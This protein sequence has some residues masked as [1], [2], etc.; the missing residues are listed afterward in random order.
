MRLGHPCWSLCFAIQT[1]LA[2][3]SKEREGKKKIIFPMLPSLKRPK[4]TT[5]CDLAEPP[6]FLLDPAEATNK[7][8]LEAFEFFFEKLSKLKFTETTPPQI[9]SEEASSSSS[10]YSSRQ[11]ISS[12]LPSSD[13]LALDVTASRKRVSRDMA[14]DQ[15]GI[16]G[17][18]DF[19]EHIERL[20][21]KAK[22]DLQSDQFDPEAEESKVVVKKELFS[23]LQSQYPSLKIDYIPSI[24]HHWTTCA[25]E[26]KDDL[27]YLAENAPNDQIEA[28]QRLFNVDKMQT[29][30][31]VLQTR[32]LFPA[33][34]KALRSMKYFN[35]GVYMIFDLFPDARLSFNLVNNFVR[36]KNAVENRML[37]MLLERLAFNIESKHMTIWLEKMRCSDNF[38]HLLFLKPNVY[39]DNRMVFA[40]IQQKRPIPIISQI[41]RKTI[42]IKSSILELSL[43][44]GLAESVILEMFHQGIEGSI[45]GFS[46][47][48]IIHG[49]SQDV[50]EALALLKDVPNDS[51]LSV[52]FDNSIPI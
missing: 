38:L 8:R 15:S 18:N 6:A 27:L 33:L 1:I 30:F 10:S 5:A 11:R 23:T 34:K 19:D 40:A 42:S 24:Y 13:K 46:Q 35:R 7:E 29:L 41:V 21:Q 4:V 17:A 47:L 9:E 25:V 39:G 14:S 48:A 31:L 52:V 28:L 16:P 26:D 50:T 51:A 22:W 3:S 32:P 12:D 45:K 20:L 36:A 37:E 43:T 2:S 49:Y 44:M